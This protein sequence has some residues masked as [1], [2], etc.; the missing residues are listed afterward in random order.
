MGWSLPLP[1][2][3]TMSRIYRCHSRLS[4]DLQGPVVNQKPLHLRQSSI[5]G[6]C[7]PHCALMALQLL[8][9]VERDE[10]D[11]IPRAASKRLTKLWERAAGIYFAGSR[12]K[13]L[14]ALLEP[15]TDTVRSRFIRKLS[16]EHAAQWLHND[17]VCIVGISNS[18]FSHWVVAVGVSAPDEYQA[19]DALLILDPDAPPV[20]M[21]PWNAVLHVSLNRNKRH[22]YL[23]VEGTCKVGI[24]SVLALSN[25]TSEETQLDLAD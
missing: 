23:S 25:V 12:P 16:L 20:P 11:N 19:P 22:R 10:F 13:Q 4:A 3:N 21:A 6:A 9:A 8:G 17:G 15:F 24:D 5:D 7:G 14:Q 18:D 1:G 2:E